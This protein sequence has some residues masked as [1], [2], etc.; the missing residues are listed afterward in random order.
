MIRSAAQEEETEEDASIELDWGVLFFDRDE[1]KE[2]LTL[3]EQV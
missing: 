1:W 3:I 2:F